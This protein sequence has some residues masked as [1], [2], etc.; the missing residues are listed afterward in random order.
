MKELLRLSDLKSILIRIAKISGKI[1]DKAGR[2]REIK[3]TSPRLIKG[4]GDKKYPQDFR[5]VKK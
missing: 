4:K 2:I 5:T 3:R 1:K